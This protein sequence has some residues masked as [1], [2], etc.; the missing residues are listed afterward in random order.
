MLLASNVGFI[1]PGLSFCDKLF[2]VEK[3]FALVISQHHFINTIVVTPIKLFVHFFVP[4]GTGVGQG[5]CRSR[6]KGGT[7]PVT[8]LPGLRSMQSGELY[9]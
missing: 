8:S 5:F 1:C 3:H 2:E 6:V 9:E 4:V 7:N